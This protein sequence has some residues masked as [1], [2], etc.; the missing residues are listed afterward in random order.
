MKTEWHDDGGV[1]RVMDVKRLAPSRRQAISTPVIDGADSER[2]CATS[3]LS[4]EG[5][6]SSVLAEVCPLDARLFVRRA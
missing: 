2:D 1:N 3:F 4:R 6:C 5:R